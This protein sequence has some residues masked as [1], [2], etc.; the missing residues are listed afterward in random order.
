[1]WLSA[2]DLTKQFH[3]HNFIQFSREMRGNAGKLAYA[4][5]VGMVLHAYLRAHLLSPSRRGLRVDNMITCL[6]NTMFLPVIAYSILM[7]NF[8]IRK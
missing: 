4:F 7:I 5:R 3:T 1:M 6:V 8:R 2:L